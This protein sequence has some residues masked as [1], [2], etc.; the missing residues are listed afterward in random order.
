LKVVSAEDEGESVKL[1]LLD[2]LEKL[3]GQLEEWSEEE[4][5]THRE[6]R[7]KKG[8]LVIMHKISLSNNQL[9]TISYGTNY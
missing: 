9:L 5:F 6:G 8:E 3:E 7:R 4:I 2:T 1:D